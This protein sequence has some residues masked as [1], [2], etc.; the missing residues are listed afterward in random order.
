VTLTARP[1]PPG[2]CRRT[3][4]S[5]T[6]VRSSP[7]APGSRTPQVNVVNPGGDGQTAH[8]DNHLGF[9]S[10]E[11]C[12]RYPAHVHALSQVLTLQGAVAHC[13]MPV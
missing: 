9:Q 5:P 3:A 12:A 10:D 6:C 13:D 2:S 4:G 1:A 8:G 7:S 11:T